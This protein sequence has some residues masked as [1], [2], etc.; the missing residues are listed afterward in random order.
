MLISI[1]FGLNSHALA[2]NL[3]EVYQQALVSDQ[4]F[5][6]AIAQRFSDKEGVPISLSYLLPTAG[7]IAEPTI[8]KSNISGAGASFIGSNTTRGYEVA[9]SLTQTVF[10][11]AQFSNLCSAKAISREA[12]AN[13]NAAVQDLML[14]VAKAYFAVLNDEDNLSY[15]IANKEAYAKQLDQV[16]QQYNVGLK[17]ITDV[18]TARASYD[19][20]VAQY[21]TAVNTL[22]DD[23]ENL[24]VITG[25]LYPNLA[26]LSE[27]FPYVSPKPANMESW[28]DIAL[29]QNWSIKAAHFSA[30][31]ARQNIKQQ[32]AGNYPTL[33]A[34]GNYAVDFTRVFTHAV[35][36]SSII[37]PSP[38]PTPSPLPIPEEIFPS[39]PTRIKTAS[40]NLTLNI[41]LIQGG[42]VIANTKKAKFDYKVAISKFDQTAREV[43]NNTRQSYLGILSGISKINADKQTI[44]SSISSLE[45]LRAS[46]E[47]GT[48]T[49]VDVLNQQ[50]QVYQAQQQYANDR[51]A[52]INNFLQLK[53]AAGTLSVAD[54]QAIN[55]WLVNNKEAE[56]F[57]SGE[58]IPKFE[59]ET[60][61]TKQQTL[62]ETKL[63]HSIKPFHHAKKHK[64]KV[65]VSEKIKHAMNHSKQ[66]HLAKSTH[67]ATKHRLARSEKIKP[68]ASHAKQAHSFKPKPYHAAVKTN[69]NIKS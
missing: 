19:G 40:A 28:V 60:K 38:S 69:Q 1:F 52:Y 4:V 9:L 27:K 26:K 62:K 48:E 17:T 30:E 15:T 51:Y 36:G 46:Y 61:T 18:Y 8:S 58:D 47:V 16:T 29:R 43:V 35:A 5:Q 32:A 65:I 11:Y 49:L 41:P 63:T 66:M 39:G 22:Q 67:N 13:L 54:L 64:S 10:N 3:M 42:Y 53:D 45:G 50:K 55:C 31:S 2:A 6:Q 68:T 37:P 23:K 56:P 44:K 20:S 59:D 57:S 7:I 14:R 21:I 24:R 12:D 34:Q 33:E 25:V